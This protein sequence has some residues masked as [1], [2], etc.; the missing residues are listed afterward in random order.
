MNERE[1]K[2]IAALVLSTTV[3]ILRRCSVIDTDD[4]EEIEAACEAQEIIADHLLSVR[5]AFVS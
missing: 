4:P 3:D 1:K 2:Q 5:K